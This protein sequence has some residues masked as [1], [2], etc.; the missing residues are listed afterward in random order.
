MGEG[1]QKTVGILAEFLTRAAD[2]LPIVLFCLSTG[3][4][5]IIRCHLRRMHTCTLKWV[6]KTPSRAEGSRELLTVHI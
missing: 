6:R 3:L 5:D 4:A 1:F 2:L